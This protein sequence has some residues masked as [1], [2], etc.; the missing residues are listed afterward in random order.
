MGRTER[1]HRPTVALAV[2]DQRA[3]AHDGV[4]DVLRKFVA[5]FLTNVRVRL[6][7]EIVGRREPSEVGYGLQ[8]PDDNAWFHADRCA[9]AAEDLRRDDPTMGFGHFS[10]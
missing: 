5:E 1:V 7:D 10:L 8:V 4:V 9:L 6:A 3:D 2:S